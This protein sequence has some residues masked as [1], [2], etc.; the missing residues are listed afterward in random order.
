MDKK[1]K[2]ILFD[3]A[4]SV[5]LNEEVAN[6]FLREQGIDASFYI[7]KTLK[8][9]KRKEF[10][11]KA[12]INLSKHQELI[13]QAINK[14][15]NAIPE[16]ITNFEEAIRRRNPAFQF[17][18]LKELDEQQLREVLEDVDLINTIEELDSNE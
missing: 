13:E 2:K 7:S 18:N 9:I 3:S 10:L 17:R 12:E 11:K 16:A 4:D 14:I 5:S 1:Y 6:E 8:V 15:R